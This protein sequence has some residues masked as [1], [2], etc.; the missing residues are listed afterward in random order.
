MVPR[1]KKCHYP[2]WHQKIL[3][4]CECS[5]ISRRP[6]KW[7]LWLKNVIICINTK[8]SWKSVIFPESVA[9]QR[10]RHLRV[11]QSKMSLSALALNIFESLR[12]PNNQLQTNE[13]DWGLRGPKIG[14]QSIC[15][16]ISEVFEDVSHSRRCRPVK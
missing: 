2:H 12:V 3:K 8:N 6:P 4:V 16:K 7:T 13:M 11:P 1:S 10:N 14:Y 9:D 15:T 5:R